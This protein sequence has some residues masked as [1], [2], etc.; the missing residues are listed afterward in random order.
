MHPF[1]LARDRAPH[2][3]PNNDDSCLEK[4]FCSFAISQKK[5]TNHHTCE[6]PRNYTFSGETTRN[7]LVVR[8]LPIKKSQR[9]QISQLSVPTPKLEEKNRFFPCTGIETASTIVPHDLLQKPSCTEFATPTFMLP[10]MSGV[11]VCIP[12]SSV[13]SHRFPT[14]LTCPANQSTGFVRCA[15][16]ADTGSQLTLASPRTKPG[17]SFPNHLLRVCA[18]LVCLV[19]V[20]GTQQ[21]LL[22][23]LF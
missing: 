15:T 6:M 21:I 10:K 5:L 13:A 18:D 14:C 22:R 12:V 19:V 16:S 2:R 20:I 3:F 7:P 23:R 17:F 11:L 4:L 8:E 9:V 1:L